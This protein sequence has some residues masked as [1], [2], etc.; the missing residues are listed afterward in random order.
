MK[1]K[2]GFTL[3]EI[4]IA[5]TL[6]VIIVPAF[7]GAILSSLNNE[8]DMNQ[9]LK[10]NRISNSIIETLK[11]DSFKSDLKDISDGSTTIK[12]DEDESI[13]NDYTINLT[14]NENVNTD[15]SI[16][17]TATNT[18]N[19]YNIKIKW[20]NINYSLETLIAGDD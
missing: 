16:E 9:R 7:T 6:L 13:Y 20:K 8:Q 12:W 15:I 5:L 17:I 18:E 4:I 2:K 10:A 11:S 1:N 19:L 3:I 14:N